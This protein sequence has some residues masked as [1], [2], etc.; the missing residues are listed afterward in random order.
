LIFNVFLLCTIYGQSIQA[1]DF[2]GRGGRQRMTI[3]KVI[4]T[5]GGFELNGFRINDLGLTS[6]TNLKFNG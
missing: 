3:N 1:L 5:N 4:H 6:S 2:S